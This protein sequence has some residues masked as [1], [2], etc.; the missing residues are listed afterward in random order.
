MQLYPYQVTY[1]ESMPKSGIM[2]AALGSGKTAMA[3]MHW[4]QQHPLLVVAPAAKI[5]T[6]DWQEEAERW[7]GSD[8]AASIIFISYEKL[9]LN[10]SKTIRPNWWQ[11]VARRNRGII[12]DVICDEAQALKNPQS[13]QAKA[14]LEIK[15]SGGQFIGL[16]G[17]PMSN[18]WI[19]FAG[20]SKL[21]GFVAG[22]TEFKRKYCYITTYGGFPRIQG[23]LNVEELERQWAH[24]SRTLTREQAHELPNRQFIGKTI[25]LNPKEQ[26]NYSSAKT[27][28]MVE[29]D[30]KLLDNPSLLLNYL[31]QTSTASRLDALSDILDDTDENIIVFYNYISERKA[32]IDYIKK[33]HKQK[34]LLR[35]D[36]EKHDTLPKSDAQLKNVV[37]LAHYKSAS[38]GLNLQWATV[39]VYFS[40][41]YSYQEFEQS[42]A[43]THRT[44]QTKKC[45]F[46]IFKAKN[47]VDDDIYRALKHKRDFSTALWAQAIDNPSAF[48]KV[49]T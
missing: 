6:G 18:G 1:L 43:R 24:I 10:D 17:T 22:I 30:G 38:T 29:E 49:N 47:T 7:L 45:L 3:L 40:L 19:D 28:R 9:R 33:H 27:L 31:R 32:I 46:Y 20:Y 37:L 26:K 21:F 2:H 11:F 12:Y 14:V 8:V 5:R 34:K 44:G 13:K 4:Q 35:Y 48:D 41:T 39:T 23:Y 25:H 36:G 16:T 42:I 15:Q